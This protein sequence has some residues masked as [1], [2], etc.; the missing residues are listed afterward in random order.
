M[1]SEFYTEG[2]VIMEEEQMDIENYD[3][4]TPQNVKN[5]ANFKPKLEPSFLDGIDF[6]THKPAE[7]IIN[8][9]SSATSSLRNPSGRINERFS[10]SSHRGSVATINEEEEEAAIG[11]GIGGQANEGQRT[12]CGYFR[13]VVMQIINS[14]FRS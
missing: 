4:Q 5:F 10:F 8:L 9:F 13:K 11:G 14:I 6:W 3:N 1:T 7:T 12:F 2:E